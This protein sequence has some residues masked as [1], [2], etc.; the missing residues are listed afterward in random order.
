MIF[1]AERESHLRAVLAAAPDAVVVIDEQGLIEEF[2]PSAERQ[3]GYTADEVRGR[4][5]KL[6]MPE[7]YRAE[8]DGYMHRYLTTGERRIIGIGRV[9]VGQRKDGSTFPLELHVG[10]VQTGKRRIFIGFLRDLT[11]PQTTRARLQELQQELL[12]AARLRA[13]GQ[14]AAALAHELNQPLTAVANYLRGVLR[15]LERE[16]ADMA[17]VREAIGL[18]AEQTLRAGEI[19]RRLRDFVA[20]GE[21]NRR[22]ER[23]STL[24]EEASALALVGARERNV[25]VT[26]N[27][28]TDLPLVLVERVPV[29]QVLLNLMRNAVEAMA[30][31]ERRTLTVTAAASGDHVTIGVAD[32]G[33]GLSPEVAVQLFQPFVTTK[34]DGMGIGLSICRTIIEAHGGRIWAE[35]NPGGGTV[36]RLTLPVAQ[37]ADSV[38]D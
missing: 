10:E 24:I 8:H 7:P 25:H 20:R 2:S 13:T 34:P 17:R 9:V 6:L 35:A 23:V 21:V 4:N 11:E 14:M 36:F 1:D 26:L 28:P 32:T 12:L 37:A 38:P 30:E 15:L 3:F 5:V 18:A 27:V 22:P 31:T 29:E 33:P 19:I 16:Q